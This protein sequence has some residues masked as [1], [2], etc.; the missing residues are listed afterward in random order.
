MIFSS[1]DPHNGNF[2]MDLVTF[3]TAKKENITLPGDKT[4]VKELLVT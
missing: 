1:F 3:I 2:G 4:G